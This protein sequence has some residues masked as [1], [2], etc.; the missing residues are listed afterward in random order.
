M[1]VVLSVGVAFIAG[2]NG[3]LS[4]RC[5]ARCMT[6]QSSNEGYDR[7]NK[8]RVMTAICKQN[9]KCFECMR[10]CSISEVDLTSHKC[11]FMCE[12]NNYEC[13]KSCEFLEYTLVYKAGKCPN[14]ATAMGFESVCLTSC[15]EDSDCPEHRKC[16]PNLCGYVC[17]SPDFTKDSLPPVPTN[18][19]VKEIKQG[20]SLQLTWNLPVHSIA[21]AGIIVYVI[22]QRNTTSVRPVWGVDTPWQILNLTATTMTIVKQ[23]HAGHWFQYRVAAVTAAGTQGYSL[24]SQPFK[25]S[26]RVQR[27]LPPQNITEGVTTLRN[28]HVDVTIHW[29]PPK[30]S[31][32]P[33]WKYMIMWN[34]KLGSVSPV[35]IKIPVLETFI[36]GNIHEYKLKKLKPGTTYHIQIEAIVQ[37]ANRELRSNKVSKYI[38]TYSPPN[39]KEDNQE[40]AYSVYHDILQIEKLHVVDSA[41]YFDKGSLKAQLRWTLSSDIQRIVKSFMI[42]WSP[43]YC[44]QE[45]AVLKS[46]SATSDVA[47]F[48]V[49]DLQF[50]CQ[51]IINVSA[52]T[53]SG[54]MGKQATVKIQTPVCEKILVK[55]GS[56]PPDCPDRVSHVPRKPKQIESK[57]IMENCSIAI[58]LTWS[59]PKSDLPIDQYVLTYQMTEQF[60]EKK[61]N[62]DGTEY[63]HKPSEI[64]LDKVTSYA[65]SNL[66]Q[67]EVYVIRLHAVSRAGKGE[68]EYIEILTP[69]ILPCGSDKDPVPPDKQ[70]ESKTTLVTSTVFPYQPS[71]G[72][73]EIKVITRPVSMTT[74]TNNISSTKSP[75]GDIWSSNI[76]V[77]KTIYYIVFFISKLFSKS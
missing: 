67:S 30:Y 66:R 75:T 70:V 14:P 71:E 2:Q 11:A 76:D 48:E 43:H 74:D 13:E 64:I 51:Y 6:E 24:P 39:K 10:P 63:K 47:S 1:D 12:N 28:G 29:E 33:V 58:E 17:R 35:L 61:V 7:S 55:G 60:K 20:R 31:D 19:T 21:V 59:H 26:K 9:S 32:V 8:S 77:Y 62:G 37:H 23:L 38:T 68:A 57:I 65:I 40:P 36:A 42:F 4:A 50:E 3:L 46:Y 53:K 54:V 5:A 52:V 18:I 73:T 34:E 49:Y 72:S 15:K 41:P 56:L 16:C 44:D 45:F 22:E 25:S 69:S 27:P